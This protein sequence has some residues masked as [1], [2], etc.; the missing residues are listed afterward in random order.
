MEQNPV[1]GSWIG[2]NSFGHC[3][4]FW[5]RHFREA[6]MAQFHHLTTDRR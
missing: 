6:A 5:I 2:V 3:H 1:S 4:N